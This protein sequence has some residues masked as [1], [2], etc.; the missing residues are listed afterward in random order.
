M[1]NYVQQKEILFLENNLYW[2]DVISNDFCQLN[3]MKM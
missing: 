2:V 3:K 1:C